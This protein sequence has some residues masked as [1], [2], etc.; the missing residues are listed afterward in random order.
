[1]ISQSASEHAQ[2]VMAEADFR[3]G[4]MSGVFVNEQFEKLFQRHNW[5]DTSC[6]TS[7]GGLNTITQFK[8]GTRDRERS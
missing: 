8:R 1:M 4:R 6:C 3:Q 2:S 7:T 5:L